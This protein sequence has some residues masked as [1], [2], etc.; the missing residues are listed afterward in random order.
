MRNRVQA[1]FRD[2]RVTDEPFLGL[3]DKS[4]GFGYN[5]YETKICVVYS[6]WGSWLWCVHASDS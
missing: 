5:L 3:F 1:I 6:Q 2:S 4:I